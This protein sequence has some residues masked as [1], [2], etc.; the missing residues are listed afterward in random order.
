MN[1]YYLSRSRLLFS[2]DMASVKTARHNMRQWVRAIRM[3]GQ[4]WI[5]SRE[6]HVGR[7]A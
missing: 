6:Q 4:R 3:L 7:K 5:L 1:T 2:N